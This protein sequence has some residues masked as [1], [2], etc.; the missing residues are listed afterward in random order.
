MTRTHLIRAAALL[1]TLAAS[2][3]ETNNTAFAGPPG[4]PRLPLAGAWRVHYVTVPAAAPGDAWE[5]KTFDLPKPITL[6]APSGRAKPGTAVQGVW[7]ERAVTVPAEWQGRR[8]VIR[9]PRARYGAG[10]TVN[11]RNAFDLTVD[12]RTE[13]VMFIRGMDGDWTEAQLQAVV[14]AEVEAAVAR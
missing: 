3:V 13:K 10:I 8:T 7:F 5:T 4:R 2:A 1:M 9:V 6:P 11:G 12:G 14:K